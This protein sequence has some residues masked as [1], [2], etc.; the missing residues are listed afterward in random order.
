[1]NL[2]DLVAT[3]RRR[4]EEYALKCADAR[5]R[6]SQKEAAMFAWTATTWR[7]AANELEAE[8]LRAS[9]SGCATMTPETREEER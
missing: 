1:M 6:N 2:Q 4:A 3:W 5:K 9:S 7:A 8:I